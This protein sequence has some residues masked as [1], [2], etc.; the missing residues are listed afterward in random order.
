MRY[1]RIVVF[2]A[3]KMVK[4]FTETEN[5]RQSITW[6]FLL[7]LEG[8]VREMD[9]VPEFSFRHVN[10]VLTLRNPRDQRVINLEII[11]GSAY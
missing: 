9:R 7:L 5:T 2:V 8:F 6:L 1:K 3:G 4:S 10:F 11:Y